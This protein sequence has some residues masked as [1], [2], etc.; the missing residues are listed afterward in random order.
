VR[1][2]ITVHRTDTFIYKIK[3][4]LNFF[5]VG[6]LK[7]ICVQGNYTLDRAIAQAVSRLLPNPAARVQ[8]RVCSCGIL[9]W[10]KVELGQDF[11]ENFGFPGNLHSI[12]FSTII[13]IITRGWRNRP[14]VAAVPIA[15]Q[16]N[17]KN[18]TL[19][20]ITLRIAESPDFNCRLLF[21]RNPAFRE[22]GS[23]TVYRKNTVE[24]YT[25]MKFDSGHPVAPFYLGGKTQ[26][27]HL[28]YFKA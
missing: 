3:L 6:H 8:T 21:W 16:T 13:F 1:R 22:T 10:T 11:S 20:N 17:K 9:W 24:A 18:C 26:H 14:G 5:T 15:S 28:L 4:L 25:Q 27:S 2:D 7:K 12:C 19:R 23:I